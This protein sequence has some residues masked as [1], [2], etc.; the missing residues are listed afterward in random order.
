MHMHTKERSFTCSYAGCN[1]SF[2]DL[3]TLTHHKNSHINRDIHICSYESCNDAFNDPLQLQRH[4]NEEHEMITISVEEVRPVRL[5]LTQPKRQTPESFEDSPRKRLLLRPPKKEIRS[6]PLRPDLTKTHESCPESS[7][8]VNHPTTSTGRGNVHQEARSS[9]PSMNTSS[10]SKTSSSYEVFNHG[11]YHTLPEI[12]HIPT[13]S[14][15]PQAP[16]LQRANEQESA[17]SNNHTFCTNKESSGRGTTVNTSVCGVYSMEKCSPKK[18]EARRGHFHCPRCDT[19]FTRSCNVKGHFVRCITMHGNPDCLKWTDHPSLEKTA[20]FYARNGRRTQS[21]DPLS[22]AAEVKGNLRGF[23]QNASLRALAPKPLPPIIQ[24]TTVRVEP[25]SKPLR[26]DALQEKDIVRP[27]HMGRDALRRSIYNPETIARDFLLA[28][29]SHPNMGPLNIHLDILQKRFRFVNDDSNMS[30]FRWDLVDPEQ[31]FT[32]ELERGHRKEHELEKQVEREAEPEKSSSKT[33]EASEKKIRF[34]LNDVERSRHL[35]VSLPS[36]PSTK[37]DVLYNEVS[38]RII[39]PDKTHFGPM[40]TMFTTVFNRD[41]SAR[42]MSSNED[43]WA[44]IFTMLEYRHHG[45]KPTIRA[46]VSKHS[47]DILGWTAYHD[48]DP[49]EAAPTHH[50]S[51][52]LD[53]MTAAQLLPPQLYRFTTSHGDGAKEKKKEAEHS[54]RGNV[55]SRALASTIRARVTEAQEYLVP[56]RHVVINALVVHPLCQGRG[57]GSALLR[58]VTEIADVE[59]APVWIH[60]PDDAAVMVAPGGWSPKVGLFRRAGFE[61]AGELNLDLDAYASLKGRERD[62]GKGISF[63]IYKRNYLLRWPRPVGP[64]A[65]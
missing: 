12:P 26:W 9:N 19:Q 55:R 22:L 13:L 14:S 42:L 10:T 49:L 15:R 24:E 37:Q 56:V 65:Q 52:N 21:H 51:A 23:S 7:H 60:A 29:G 2:C 45:P 53:W 36:R 4:Y 57:V 39:M 5:R 35:P 44:A 38:F 47:S 61:C 46:A 41:P 8:V 6:H 20:S 33:S 27:I 59:R 3:G 43:L 50:P 54:D 30:T 40:S 62:K 64:K 16:A 25:M 11:S 32:K 1:K 17:K 48:V 58:S 63:G 34:K 18:I 28:T 31:D